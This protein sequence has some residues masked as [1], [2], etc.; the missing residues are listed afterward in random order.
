MVADLGWEPS[1]IWELKYRDLVIAH[2]SHL[3]AAWD[4]TSVVAAMLHNL[5]TIVINA[6]SSKARAKPRRPSDF[7]PYR[8]KVMTGL[9]VTRDNFNILR[10]IGNALVGGNRKG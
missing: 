4:H 1:S 2:D 5:G 7:H 6:L 9:K 10:T 3:L 8:K